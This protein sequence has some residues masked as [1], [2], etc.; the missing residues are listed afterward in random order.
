MEGGDDAIEMTNM[1]QR[2]KDKIASNTYMTRQE[3]RDGGGRTWKR[4]FDPL[5]LY[6]DKYLDLCIKIL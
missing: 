2:Q 1:R 6:K 5:H 3:K 4:V